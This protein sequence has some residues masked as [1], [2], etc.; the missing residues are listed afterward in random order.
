VLLAVIS[1][2]AILTNAQKVDSIYFNLYTDSLKKQ[3]HNYI[4]IDGKLADGTWLPLTDKDILFS[5]ST[6]KFQGNNL[7]I[8]SNCTDKKVSIK[9]VLKS[10]PA[11]WR[12]VT[13]YIKTLPDN[14]RLKTIDEVL[15]PSDS[16]RKKNLN[17]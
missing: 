7:I 17:E 9:A 15:R 14:E 2:F 1:S 3:V 11:I 8:D 12:E 4:N 10:N 5:S 13:V 16:R 6:G